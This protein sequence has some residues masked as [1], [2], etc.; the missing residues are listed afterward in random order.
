MT[1]KIRLLPPESSCHRILFLLS[2]SFYYICPFFVPGL[3]LYI[4]ISGS[5]DHQLQIPCWQIHDFDLLCS[6]LHICRQE[7]AMCELRY[8]FKK[9]HNQLEAGFNRKYKNTALPAHSLTSCSIF[10]KTVMEKTRLRIWLPIL[11]SNTP[12]S[13]MYSGFWKRRG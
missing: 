2:L 7:S 10:P 11:T 3:R 13:S 4:K 5:V 6:M 12:A 1:D 9:I 8:Y